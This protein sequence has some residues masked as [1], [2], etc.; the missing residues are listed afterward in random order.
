[1]QVVAMKDVVAQNQSG[2]AVAEKVFAD[3]KGLSEPIGRGLHG[4]VQIQPPL[5]AVAEQLLKARRILRG[6]NDQDVAD[7]GQ[8]QRAERI[9]DHR[10]VEDGEQLFAHRKRSRMQPRTGAAREEDAFAFHGSCLSISSSSMRS[11]WYCQSGST[12]SK[13]LRSLVV[14]SR[15]LAGRCAGVGYSRVGMGLTCSGVSASF[16]PRSSAP[17]MTCCA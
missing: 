12:R 11:T 3:K 17:P 10:L 2:G 6:G 7:A 13:V 14:S 9:V 4:V 8:H 16:C 5:F 1:M 15:E